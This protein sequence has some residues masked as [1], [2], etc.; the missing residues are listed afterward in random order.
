MTE[1]GSN[2]YAQKRQ[3]GAEPTSLDVLDAIAD[4]ILVLGTSGTVL[5]ANQAALSMLDRRD[6]H[7]PGGLMEITVISDSTPGV[8]E[9][10]VGTVSWNGIPA[11]LVQLHDL[12]PRREADKELA[13]R[14]TH[15]PL[16]GLPNRYLLDDRLHQVLARRHRAAGA[17]AVFYCDLNGLKEINDRYGHAVGDDVLIATSRRLQKV[18]RPSD[19][20]A[21]VSGDE[22]VIV[23]E[24]LDEREASSL[25]VRL[26]AAFEEPVLVDDLILPTSISVGYAIADDPSVDAAILLDRADRAMYEHKRRDL[27]S[28]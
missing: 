14:A 28:L 13:Y 10:R 19:T 5:F 20:V 8:A 11:F 23:C 3:S 27:R 22:F 12:A 25:A 21:H 2:Q 1:A 16:T 15:H 4:G 17:V 24:N 9:V 6:T 7:L 26:V 18:I